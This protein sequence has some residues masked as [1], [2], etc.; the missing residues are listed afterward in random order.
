MPQVFLIIFCKHEIVSILQAQNS[1]CGYV[2]ALR[3][4][5]IFTQMSIKA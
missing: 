4:P 5:K 2:I 1:L 3:E